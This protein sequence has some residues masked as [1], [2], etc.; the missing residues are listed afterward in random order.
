[1]K[2]RR[3]LDL[4][5]FVVSRSAHGIKDRWNPGAETLPGFSVWGSGAVGDVVLDFERRDFDRYGNSLAALAAG[6][7]RKA[8]V[9][10]L[11]H[12]GAKASTQVKREMVR[13]TG[14]PY[15]Q[16]TAGVKQRKAYAGSASGNGAVLEHVIVGTGKPLSLKYF[17]ARQVKTGV[18][19]APWN[20]RQIFAGTFSTGGSFDRG[21]KPV[22]GGHVFIRTSGKRLPLKKLY[23]PGIANELVKDQVALAFKGVA[24]G[25]PARLGHEISRLL[26][27]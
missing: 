19:A 11:N 15:G 27:A 16:I 26:P 14:I 13:Q 10:A 8:M 18:S 22:M 6:D 2:I 1:M 9:R 25:L 5:R 12:Q 4:R 17:K 24:F 3:S 21:R 23:G 7:A 20:K